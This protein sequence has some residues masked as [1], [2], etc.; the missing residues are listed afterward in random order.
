MSEM[1]DV[2]NDI[3]R[4]RRDRKRK[5]GK[6]CPECKRLRPNTNATILL[7]GQICKVDGYKDSRI[8]KYT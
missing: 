3:K 1:A 6:E 7:P 8:I 5:F 4:R 2:Y